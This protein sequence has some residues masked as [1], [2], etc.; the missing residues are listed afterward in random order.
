[1]GSARVLASLPTRRSSDLLEGA[2]V[3]HVDD[4]GGLL[5]GVA[6]TGQRL[7]RQDQVV[8]PGADVV[9][10]LVDPVIAGIL[11]LHDVGQQALDVALDRKSTR[12]NS[13]HVKIS[14]A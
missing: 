2:L 7:F 3:V 12:L 4:R 13:S 11:L 14:Y 6:G 10:D 8:L 5:A 9:L 1:L